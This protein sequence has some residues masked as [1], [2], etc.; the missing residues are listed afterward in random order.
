MKMRLV[1]TPVSPIS[2]TEILSGKMLPEL[3]EFYQ[4]PGSGISLDHCITLTTK[5]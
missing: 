1:F 2:K 3:A 5:V 4:I